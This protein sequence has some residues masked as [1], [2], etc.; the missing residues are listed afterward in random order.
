MRPRRESKAGRRRW[1]QYTRGMTTLYLSGGGQIEDVAGFPEEV[2]EKID[3]ARQQDESWVRLTL[4][5]PTSSF[6]GEKFEDESCAVRV[7]GIVA[8]SGRSR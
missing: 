7:D 2:V 3:G 1:A 5:H 6:W 4:K 8:V